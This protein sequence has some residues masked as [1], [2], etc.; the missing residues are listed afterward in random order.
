MLD[1]LR[2]VECGSGLAGALCSRI[3]ADL[4]ADV[5]KIEAR[6]GDP[7]RRWGPFPSG[8]A[9]AE[10]SGLF[11]YYHAGLPRRQA[12]HRPRQQPAG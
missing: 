8:E 4:G 3:P 10:A 11:H 9:D 1:G 5:I 6:V 2:G 7:L 12:V